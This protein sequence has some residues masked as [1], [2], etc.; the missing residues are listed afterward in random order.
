MAGNVFPLSS[1]RLTPGLPYV[2]RRKLRFIGAIA[3]VSLLA[4]FILLKRQRIPVFSLKPPLYENFRE[5]ERHLPHYSIYEQ[6]TTI[7][8]FW[9]A[10][11][12]YGQFP[13][14]VCVCASV[15]VKKR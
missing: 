11:L 12:M 9:A 13:F 4:F 10:Q 1:S 5:V 8:Y 7:K 3:V 15:Q 6:N 2:T 14:R